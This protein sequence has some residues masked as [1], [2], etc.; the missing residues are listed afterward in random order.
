MEPSSISAPVVNMGWWNLP[1]VDYF[2]FPN[3][4]NHLENPYPLVASFEDWGFPHGKLR[5]IFTPPPPQPTQESTHVLG[6][7]RVKTP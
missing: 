3:N 4:W 2:W 7:L 5:D 6:K 1:E